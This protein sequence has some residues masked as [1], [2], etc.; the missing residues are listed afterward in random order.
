MRIWADVRTHGT[1]PVN[2]LLQEAHVVVRR[3]VPKH[4]DLL[5]EALHGQEEK[6]KRETGVRTTST[7]TCL[8]GCAQ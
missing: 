4:R 2:R 5:G 6:K 8:R 7:S 1:Q 3:Y